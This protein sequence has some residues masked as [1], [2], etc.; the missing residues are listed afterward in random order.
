M[1]DF[2]VQQEGDRDKEGWDGAAPGKTGRQRKKAKQKIVSR[3]CDKTDDDLPG[4][5]S[6]QVMKSFV[7]LAK[8]NN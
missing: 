3:V 1:T 4:E 2:S 8:I 7:L 6:T 5:R